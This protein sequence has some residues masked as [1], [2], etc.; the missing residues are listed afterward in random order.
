MTSSTP[1]PPPPGGLPPPPRFLERLLRIVER[2]PGLSGKQ[3][4]RQ[5]HVAPKA[6]D[7]AIAYAIEKRLI[8]RR[9]VAY[10]NADGDPRTRPGLFLVGDRRSGPAGRHK[11]GPDP[12]IVAARTRRLA[13]LCLPALLKRLE[14]QDGLAAWQLRQDPDLAAYGADID[15]AIALARE[16]RL[17]YAAPTFYV[18]AGNQR[19]T[20][21]GFYLGAEPPTPDPE[22]LEGADLKKKRVELRRSQ[23]QLA[24]ALGISTMLLASWERNGM[25]LARVEERRKLDVMRALP[26]PEE[27]VAA[28]VETLVR[29]VEGKEGL[30]RDVL[31]S[32]LHHAA[33]PPAVARPSAGKLAHRALVVALKEK[34]VHKRHDP[35]FNAAGIARTRCGIYPGPRPPDAE[36][37]LAG[38]WL[39]GELE[40]LD[41]T[42]ADLADRVG[43]TETGVAYWLTHGVPPA[44]APAVRLAL[45]L[46][47]PHSGGP[48][49]GAQGR[50]PEVLA[51]IAAHPPMT[52][53]EL[54][55]RFFSDSRVGRAAIRLAIASDQAHLGPG[56]RPRVYP[57]PAPPITDEG[58]V[59]AA[60][61][62]ARLALGLTQAELG[63]QLDRSGGTVSHWENRRETIPRKWHARLRDL[64][65]E[66]AAALD[67]LPPA[68]QSPPEISASELRRL[69]REAKLS[70]AQ[71]GRRL[72][73]RVSKSLVSAW[74]MGRVPVPPK[75]REPLRAALAATV[76]AV[77]LSA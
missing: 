55:H 71:L 73:P 7:D 46:E 49:K 13:E 38:T 5:A 59:A 22:R 54:S 6:V 50:V 30:S 70:Q 29:I 19:R 56:P 26:R 14:V 74:E 4:K 11:T 43:V 28:L 60:L 32:R 44:R 21:T 72:D 64:S 36:A 39:S 66:L 76:R 10:V 9:P 75:W 40:R 47:K 1:S 68:P 77:V 15:K 20:R 63:K 53:R 58:D 35:Y 42:R 23:A 31:L 12:K 69:R 17:I 8:E 18:S 51:A 67:E 25:P 3:I 48:R 16:R 37:R 24:E 62:K 61:R 52:R 45:E 34:R 41:W 27:H 57:G 33:Q 2:T 65:P